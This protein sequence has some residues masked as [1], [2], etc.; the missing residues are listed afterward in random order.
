MDGRCVVEI[1]A[2]I[3]GVVDASAGTAIYQSG[4][5]LQCSDLPVPSS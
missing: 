4:N 2:C 1:E 3:D 5:D